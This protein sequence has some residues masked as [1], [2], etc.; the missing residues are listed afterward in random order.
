MGA[1]V[2][3][4]VAYNGTTATYVFTVDFDGDL[5]TNT[6]QD[7]Y[8]ATYDGTS[9]SAA[10]QLTN[11]SV[12]DANPQLAYAGNG[13]LLLVWYKDGQLMMARNLDMDNAQTIV[14]C[15]D[16]S[17]GA[18]FQLVVGNNGQISIIWTDGSPKGQDV[19]LAT[20]DPGLNVWGRGMMVTD[21]ESIERSLAAIQD[22][23]GQR[24]L[25]LQ[26]G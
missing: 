14:N 17:G 2:K 24:G 11:D 3:A 26:Q 10:T 9:W 4:D 7:L 8:S 23:D 21:T 1:I 6:D 15:G 13:D 25:G 16:S 12:Q 5:S 19:Y 20:Y 22:S 18:D